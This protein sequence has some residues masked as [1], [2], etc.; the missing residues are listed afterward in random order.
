MNM[1]SSDITTTPRIIASHPAAH[2][3]VP[4]M[5]QLRTFPLFPFPPSPPLSFLSLPLLSQHTALDCHL[6]PDVIV[7]VKT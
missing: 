3:F 5:F 2:R 7:A 4:A 1:T 6:H